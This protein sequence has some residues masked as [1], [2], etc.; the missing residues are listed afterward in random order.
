MTLV[1]EW[2]RRRKK[3]R[4]KEV[5][6]KKGKKKEEKIKKWHDTLFNSDKLGK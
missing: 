4:K 5:E 1:V 3:E 6:I 2:V